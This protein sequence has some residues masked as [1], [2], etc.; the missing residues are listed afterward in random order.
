M[1]SRSMVMEHFH[2]RNER[3][4]SNAVTFSDPASK[5]AYR[6]LPLDTGSAADPVDG[7]AVLREPVDG[8]HENRPSFVQSDTGT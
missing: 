5:V 4:R 3:D 8:A 6:L 2:T 7:I 1:L